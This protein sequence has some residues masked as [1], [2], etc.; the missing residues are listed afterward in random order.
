MRAKIRRNAVER[1]VP[2][3]ARH[4]VRP[5]HHRMQ[6]R[7]FETECLAKRRAL[8]AQP[9]EIGRMIRIAG[10][11]RAAAAVGRRQHTAAHAA[12]GACGAHSPVLKIGCGHGQ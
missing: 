1:V 4:A 11:R 7:G 12:I 8:R 10:D 2:R 6:Q 5:A 9:P 3:S